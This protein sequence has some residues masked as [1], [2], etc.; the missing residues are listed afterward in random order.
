MRVVAWQ[1]CPFRRSSVHR[2]IACC[3][4]LLFA[5]G[6]GCW[7]SGISS[8]LDGTY[9]ANVALIS[10]KTVGRQGA[11]AACDQMLPGKASCPPDLPDGV[12]RRQARSCPR[13]PYASR[14]LRIRQAAAGRFI[15]GYIFLEP[16]GQRIVR[17]D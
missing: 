12:R 8:D 9:T 1:S 4:E 15:S 13:T 16:G 10:A 2:S 14:S 6:G 11:V 17:F 5:G 3:V 7:K